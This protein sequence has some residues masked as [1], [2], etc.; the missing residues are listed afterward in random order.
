MQTH[1]R[2]V[3]HLLGMMLMLASM[4]LQSA[5]AMSAPN[6]QTEGVLA[7][8]NVN[9]IPMDTERV[10]ED[11]TVVI[12]GDRIAAVG[13]ADAVTIPANAQ[14]VQAADHYLIPGLADMHWHF[15]D[16]PDS[17]T[18]A[19]A[20]GVTTIQNL[21]A[22]PPHL[23]WA[24]E[25]AAG[26]RFGPRV[27]NGPHAVG[28]PPDIQFVFGWL[29]QST[30]PLFSLNSY[31]DALGQRFREPYGFQYDAESGRRFV[32]QAKELGG[33]FIKTN[34]FVTHETFD[35]IVET[36]GELGMKVQ[37]HVWDDIGLEHYI[38]AGAQVH[39]TTELAPYL[40]RNAIQGIPAQKWD[41]QSM[42]KLP[43][44]VALMQE[45]AMAFTPTVDISWYIRQHYVDFDA[46]LQTPQIRYV[47]P[48][49]L[50]GWRNREENLVYLNFGE[51]E[52]NLEV[53]DRF[54]EFQAEL[55][56]AL[57]EADVMLLAGTDCTALPG[58]VWGYTLHQELEMLTGYDLTPYQALATAT[59][60]PAAF[61]DELDEWGTA[62]VGKR[63]DLVLLRANP[64]A[65]IANT[66]DIAGV[67]L[68]GAWHDQAALQQMLDELAAT[69]EAQAAG[70]VE[71]APFAGEAF[72]G[73]TPTGWNELQPSVYARGNP[74][75][76][77]TILG[78]FVVPTAERD[79]FL[80]EILTNLGVD[81]LP[82]EA[83]RT[84]DA[85]VL[86]WSLY[87]VPGDVMV[88]VA[89][90]EVDANTYMVVMQASADEFDGLAEALLVPAVM[91]L[92]PVK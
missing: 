39:H 69:Y 77:P 18:L 70:A 57:V 76:D 3:I 60:N 29:N 47:P 78:Q 74:A 49:T 87:L 73:V 89:L 62:E 20:N 42:D 25:V 8:V 2:R 35:A 46:L 4:M 86:S 64:L 6:Q 83:V 67:V 80:G 92:A 15:G 16:S 55:L 36:A 79:A 68:R 13:P 14:I 32:H 9:V 51:D 34:L 19:V 38:K 40:S 44:L 91:A 26:E 82:P 27:I 45:Q 88:A 65:E 58:M 84:L 1:R 7:F 43:Q 23:A 5:V 81:E 21:N 48:T 28:L 30:A 56:Q 24:A 90:A 71:L 17:L 31:V 22:E 72:S 10:L 66:Q 85:E 59:R 52:S 37:G 50:R 63:A 12:E 61:M 33:D 11:Q 41:F 54:D 75:E 53:M